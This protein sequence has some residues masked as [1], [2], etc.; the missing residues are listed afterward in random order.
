MSMSCTA[1]T[2]I[3]EQV[4]KMRKQ[5]RQ[6]AICSVEDPGKEERT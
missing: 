5:K 2:N 3:G 1:Q 4:H 6:R